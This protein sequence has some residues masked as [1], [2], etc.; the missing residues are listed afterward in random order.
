MALKYVKKKHRR[1]NIVYT[2]I[3]VLLVL[4]IFITVI[5]SFYTAAEDKAY[6]NLHMQTKQIKDDLQ[7]QIKSDNENL[8]TMANFAAKLHADGDSYALLFESFKPIGL[9]ANIGILT[10]DN[11]FETKAGSIDLNGKISFEEEARKGGYVS[12]RV[13]DLTRD[14]LEIVR[15]AAPIKVDGETVGMLYAVVKLEDLDRKYGTMAEELDAQLYVY[16]KQTGNLII[17]TIHEYPQNISMLKNRVY[18]D[19]YSYESIMATEKGY[20][21]FESVVIGEDVYVH[22]SKL[23][24]L[25]WYIL[26]ARGESQVFAEAN[27]ISRTFALSFILIFIIA[28]LHLSMTMRTEKRR[29]AVMSEASV[30]RKLLL[31]INQQHG[32]ISEALRMLCDF[33]KARSTFFVDTDGEDYNYKPVKRTDAIESEE[34]RVYL[35][36]ELLKYAAELHRVRMST[37]AIMCITPNKHLKRTNPDFYKFLK[38]HGVHEISFAAVIDKHNHISLLGAKNPKKSRSARQLAE[39][40]AV[41]F[42]IAIYNKKHLNRTEV[43]ATTDSLTGVFNRV[44]FKRDMTLFDEEHPETFSCIYIDVNELHLHNNKNGHAAGDE[45]LLYIA[46]T[47][48]EVFFGH[49]VYRMGGDEFL[50]FTQG[51]SQDDV[52]S[53]IDAV[54]ANLKPRNYHVAIGL[55]FRT[56]NTNTEEM[57]R[58]AELRMYD[59]KAQYY[60]NKSNKNAS[61]VESNSYLQLK[62]GIPEIDTMISVLKEHY[63]G[64]Y[65][66]SLNTDKAHRILMP[67]YLGYREDEENYSSLLSR[68]IEETVDSDFHRSVMSFLNYDAIR[69]QLM[70]GKTPK[71]VYKKVNGESVMLSVYKLGD[72]ADVNETLWVF[73]KL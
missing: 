8:I 54:T 61:K 47:L 28:L 63:N 65:K 43:A 2:V 27:K 24:T 16:E 46:N 57:V 15:A 50:V 68:Y 58:E 30:M 33:S 18:N 38:E 72:G 29:S 49:K 39:E 21:S 25:D 32:N 67:A 1:S 23:D 62:T 40:I 12:G 17:D 26:L 73:S 7:L 48:K 66:V 9:I 71:I 44:S 36:S 19:G 5:S 64:I 11:M 35:I 70:N 53:R 42:S 34:D 55:S 3:T 4:A 14:D 51:L 41:C 20:S 52:K 60:Q 59:A 13:K 31:E 56:Q 10:P 6:E 45:M 37:V 69:T 22:Y